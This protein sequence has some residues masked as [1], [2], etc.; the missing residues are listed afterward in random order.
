[1]RHALVFGGSGQV[2]QPLLRRLQADDWRITAVSRAPRTGVPGIDWLQGELAA[3]DGLPRQVDAIFSCGPLD[4]FAAWYAE[5]PVRSAG[6]VAFSSTSAQVK[7][8]SPDVGERD[9]AGRLQAAEDV[10]LQAAHH[11][12]AAAT[13]LRP[14]LVYGAGRDQTLS[15]VARLAQRWGRFVLPRGAT[16]ARQPVHVDDLAVAA[17]AACDSD[18][19]SARRYD[20]PGGE[21]LPY[22]E[23]IARVLGALSPPPTLHQM[24]APVFAALLRA[25]RASG[26]A[27]DLGD[28]AIVRMREDL[29]FDAGPAQR[30]FGYAP[31]AFH[32][33]ADM[34]RPPE[35]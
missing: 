15:R 11:R 3:V 29:A 32:P 7:H 28:A 26:V 2:G 4:A 35:Q 12:G 31:R 21:T 30:D 27:H 17:L 33:T 19:A 5:T 16:G 24:P 34:F 18:A 14:T 20:L 1:M 9:L 13:V 6:V 22:R 10:V 8:A 25:A 23:M